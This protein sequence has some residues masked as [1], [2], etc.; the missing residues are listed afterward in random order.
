MDSDDTKQDQLS[1]NLGILYLTGALVIGTILSEWPPE[2]QSTPPILG[3][4]LF[5]VLVPLAGA[6]LLRVLWLIV[7]LERKR[8]SQNWEF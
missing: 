7:D 5:W 6:F 4:V 8:I 1:I 2:G 3:D